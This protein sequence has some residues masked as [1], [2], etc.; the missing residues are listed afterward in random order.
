MCSNKYWNVHELVTINTEFQYFF[1][2][3]GRQE[4]HPNILL[5][6]ELR[7]ASEVKC[8]PDCEPD[9]LPANI[10]KF[11][12]VVIQIYR[13]AVYL[14]LSVTAQKL[15]TFFKLF[16]SF[17]YFASIGYSVS[18]V[19]NCGHFGGWGWGGFLPR[20]L[21]TYFNNLEESAASNFMLTELVLV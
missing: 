7:Y 18:N 17:L 21:I 6:M 11:H 1:H 9:V 3:D 15:F 12:Y 19:W 20:K 4:W 10:L 16:V 5:G 13:N 8:A 14:L 2:D